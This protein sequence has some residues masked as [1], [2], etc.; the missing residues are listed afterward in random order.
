MNIMS[1]IQEI[2]D[3]RKSTK[4]KQRMITVSEASHL[5]ERKL[6]G[7]TLEPPAFRA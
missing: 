1:K 4:D 6:K 3:L 7:F 5:W 2:N